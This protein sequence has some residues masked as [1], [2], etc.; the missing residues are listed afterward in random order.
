MNKDIQEIE[1]ITE[2]H[3]HH[4][5][6]TTKI[7][8]PVEVR[9]NSQKVYKEKKTIFRFSQI[10]WGMFSA[11]ELLLLFRVVL[12]TMGAN[13][14]AKF[15]I[16]IYNI[17]QIFISPFQGI[18]GISSNGYGIIEWSTIFA[19]FVYTCVGWGLIYLLDLLYPITPED[20]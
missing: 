19:L 13:P 20:L 6:K 5:S 3:P 16:L 10:I 17:S 1:T 7:T 14:S 2:E 18:F 9:K 8:Q 12:K 15:A 4:I 11:I